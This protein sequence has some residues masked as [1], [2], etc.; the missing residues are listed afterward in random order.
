MR[1]NNEP[2]GTVASVGRPTAAAARWRPPFAPPVPVDRVV[3]RCGVASVTSN[4]RGAGRCRSGALS[5]SQLP[6]PCRCCCRCC[7]RVY[8]MR[9]VCLPITLRLHWRHGSPPSRSHG[10]KRLKLSAFECTTPGLCSMSKSNC[11]IKSKLPSGPVDQPAPVSSDNIS[12][13]CDLHESRN[14]CPADIS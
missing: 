5:L 3:T 11:E 8:T 1:Y 9:T 7:A 13:P 10:R 4:P 2:G 14:A 12:T 6:L